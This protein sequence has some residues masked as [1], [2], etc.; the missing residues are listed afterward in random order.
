MEDFTLPD[1]HPFAAIQKAT[2]AARVRTGDKGIGTQIKAGRIQIVRAV[3]LKKGRSYAVTPLS[4]PMPW[5]EI[6]AA[7]D[8]LQPVTA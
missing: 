4:E 3:Q 2:R 6:V 5:S 1:D 8:A 7:L